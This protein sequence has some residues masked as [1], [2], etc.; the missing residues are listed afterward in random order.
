ML[1]IPS[2]QVNFG[3]PLL[4]Q[5]LDCH[6]MTFK[7]TDWDSL[8]IWCGW[9]EREYLRK[10]YTQKWRENDQEEVPEPNGQIKL[11]RIKKWEGKT[12]KKYM[13]TGS[14]RIET[15]KDI[16]VIANQYLWK[17]HKNSSI[18]WTSPYHFHF[19]FLSFFFFLLVSSFVTFIQCL[20]NVLY[21]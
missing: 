21:S 20:I 10:C 19:F 9:E 2:I 6:F 17:R 11:E 1:W 3:L 16:S 5:T 15:P 7:R 12:G 8:D 18:R 14:G 13:K 4:F